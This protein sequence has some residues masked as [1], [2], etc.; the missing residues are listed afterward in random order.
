MNL[1]KNVKHRNLD[2][3]I[4]SLEKAMFALLLVLL[5][6]LSSVFFVGCSTPKDCSIQFR[7]EVTK[8]NHWFVVTVS[9]KKDTLDIYTKT[10]FCDLQVALVEFDEYSQEMNSKKKG[11]KK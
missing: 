10:D 3:I 5:L 1:F 11:V 2:L 8:K 7:E 9:D 6:L 4:K